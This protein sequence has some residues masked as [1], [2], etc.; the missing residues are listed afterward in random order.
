MSNIVNKVKEAV[1]HHHDKPSNSTN[2]GPHDSNIANKADPRVDSDRDHRAAYSAAGTGNTT[3]GTGLSS[4]TTGTGAYG[5]ETSGYTGTTTT[6]PHDSN[7]ANKADPRVDSDRGQYGT[8]GGL[9]SGGAYDTNPNSTN[10]G[11]HSSNLA[12]KVDPRVDSDLDNRARHQNLAGGVGAPS[13]KQLQHPW[14]RH[15]PADCWS[16]RLEHCQQA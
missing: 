2:A 7:L 10:A 15:R 6:G 11:P 14:Q 8:T 1:T 3:A 16:S 4:G 12:N 5:T 13:R 9:T